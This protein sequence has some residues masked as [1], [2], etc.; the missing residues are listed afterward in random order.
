MAA[1]DSVPRAAEVL[2]LFVAAGVSDDAKRSVA[3]AIEQWIDTFP[4]ARW[5][6]PENWHITLK[7]LGATD[8]GLVPWIEGTINAIASAHAPIA[9]HLAN[10]GAF[11]TARRASVLWAGV[12][13]PEDRLAALVIE[14]EAAL[15]NEFRVEVRRFHPH[16]T[17]ARS[18]RPLSLPDRFVETRCASGPF[19]IDQ[20]IL[21]RSYLQRPHPRYEALRVFPLGR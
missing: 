14:L 21:Y 10:L 16:L 12:D 8:R 1:D 15:A 2:R 3:A 5:V 18:E 19:D 9:S 20:L 11:P 6:P 17:V 4:D 7:F 13:D